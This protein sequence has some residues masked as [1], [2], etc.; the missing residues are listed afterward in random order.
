MTLPPGLREEIAQA[1]RVRFGSRVGLS[2][3]SP[4]SGGCIHQALR[5][6]TSEGPVFVKWNEGEAGTGFGPEARALEALHAATRVPGLL[7]VPEVYGYRDGD[8][9]SDGWIAMQFLPPSP[10]ARDHWTRLGEGIAALH[11]GGEGTGRFGW[12]ET[13]RIGF[14]PQPNGWSGDWSVF[15]REQRLVPQIRGAFDEGR[16]GAGD[17]P[18]TDAVLDGVETVLQASSPHRPGLLHGDLWSGNVHAGPTG[19]PVLVDPASYFGE[20]EV[21]LAMAQLFGGFPRE[22]FD[23]YEAAHPLQP[24]WAEHRRPLYQLYY[25]LVHLRLFGRSYYSGTRSAARAAIAAL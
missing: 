2:G 21:D 10:P 22:F 12:P 9:S 25:L 16:L 11:A 14:L 6:E 5:V 3:S 8:G 24:G 18:W 13:N 17:R 23:A 19:A 20:G 7:V 1:L 15:W 4:V